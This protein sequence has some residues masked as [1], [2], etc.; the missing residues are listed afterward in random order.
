MI[1]RSIDRQAAFKSLLR[2]TYQGRAQGPLQVA[3]GALQ[4][5]REVAEARGHVGP[6]GGEP[7][8]AQ[9]PGGACAVHASK[10]EVENMRKFGE[11]IGLAFQIKDDL[12]YVDI[13]KNLA[14]FICK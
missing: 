4:G 1:D 13:I 7:P 14:R 3:V 9:P 8:R 11:L 10:K 5:A 12:L 2:W 6:D